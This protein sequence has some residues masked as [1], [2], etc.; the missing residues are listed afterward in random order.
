MMNKE[1]II[2]VTAAWNEFPE[3]F[4]WI[5]E[6][7]LALEYTLNPLSLPD[8]ARHLVPSLSAGQLIRFHGKFPGYEFGHADK[9]LAEK[10]MQT[11]LAALE[12]I[13]DYEKP[14]I[15]LHIGLEHSAP[16]D[17]HRAGENL[18]KLVARGKSL[19]VTVCI[20]NLRR[21]ISS[22]IGQLSGWAKDSG[23]QVTIDIGHAY[24]CA[25]VMDGRIS[26]TDYIAPLLPYVYEAHVYGIETDRHYPPAAIGDITPVLDSLFT[27]KCRWW[28]IELDSH[29]DITSMRAQLDAYLKLK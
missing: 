15:T 14:V 4:D 23:A 22:D 16:I 11:H 13:A 17:P 8:T 29:R 25:P 21:G 12:T 27:T 3:R 19:G 7:G 24:G 6:Q 28:T 26:V 1:P 18:N 10:G 2:A 20:E 5:R 9:T